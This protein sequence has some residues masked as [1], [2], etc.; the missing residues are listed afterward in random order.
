MVLLAP[1]MRRCGFPSSSL[2]EPD[3]GVVG[4]GV[5]GWERGLGGG[6]VAVRGVACWAGVAAALVRR[7]GV[8]VLAW[9]VA[10][11]GWVD[12]DL[13]LLGVRLRFL[14]SSMILPFGWGCQQSIRVHL[15]S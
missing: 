8:T 9:A 13:L 7:C 4:L 10:L 3:G 15:R 12:L 6:D 1:A 5:G 2:S 14:C 11:I